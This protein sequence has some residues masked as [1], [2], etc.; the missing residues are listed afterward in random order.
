MLVSGIYKTLLAC[1]AYSVGCETCTCTE[2]L[3]IMRVR[4]VG[5]RSWHWLHVGLALKTTSTAFQVRCTLVRLA[6]LRAACD[7]EQVLLGS[8]HHHSGLWLC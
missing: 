1:K 8:P 3:H 2:A 5:V 7:I 4:F 6:V